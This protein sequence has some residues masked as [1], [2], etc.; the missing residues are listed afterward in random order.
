MNQ[1]VVD[2]VAWVVFRAVHGTVNRDVSG[3]VNR[4]VYDAVHGDPRHPGLEDFLQGID[5]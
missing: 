5:I 2:V 1:N 3:A 4:T